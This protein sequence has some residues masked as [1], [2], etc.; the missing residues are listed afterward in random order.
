MNGSEII[1][2]QTE[3]IAFIIG[4]FGLIVP[5][6]WYIRRRA[7]VRTPRIKTSLGIHQ[8]VS[9]EN[10]WWSALEK[11]RSRFSFFG[12]AGE[13]ESLKESVEEACLASDLGVANTTSAIDV[14]NWNEILSAPESEREEK[15]KVAL[16]ETLQT[17]IGE[18]TQVPSENW[19]SK[20]NTSGPTVIW[21]VGVNGVGKTTSI[22]KIAR[23]LKEKGHSVLLAA[24][25][26]FRAAAS[27][28]LQTWAERLDVPCVRGSEGADSSAVLF[29]A[30][31][32]AKAKNIDF[33]LCDSAGRLHN[34]KQLMEALT[35][36]KRVM[37]KA[38]EG[39]PHE[40]LLVLDAN[41]GQNMIKQAES[42]LEDV[43]VTGLVLTK[44]DGTAKG[45]A[46]VAVARKTGLP[47]RRLGLGEKAHH[48]V[49]F[50]GDTFSKALVGLKS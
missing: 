16:A 5:I 50:D 15:T 1:L 40:T 45:G 43:Q 47:I 21:F 29:D 14:I 3:M 7:K 46:V 33:V 37:N 49:D 28:Q 2:N 9:E 4:S 41:T 22:A 42:F 12:K 20:I 31:E 38:L 17:W 32:S 23:E 8:K 35:K 10:P 19:P 13:I 11:S 25:D 18:S 30:L 36:N 24:G 27:E 34:N 39:A 26:T 48:M 6:V 44:L